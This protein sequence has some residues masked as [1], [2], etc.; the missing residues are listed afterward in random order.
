[1]S[2]MLLF[3]SFNDIDLPR[4]LKGVCSRDRSSHLSNV[5]LCIDL[6]KSYLLSNV[7]KCYFQ[8]ETQW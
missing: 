2:E 6:H 7:V 4:H 5:C 8:L 3:I 1:M